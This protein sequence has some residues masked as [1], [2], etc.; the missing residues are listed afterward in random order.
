MPDL[1]ENEWDLIINNI[2]LISVMEGLPLRNKPYMGYSIVTNTKSKEFV[3]PDE[4]YLFTNESGGLV[5]H[6]IT[7]N[8]FKNTDSFGAAY[9]NID[10]DRKNFDV[11]KED[12]TGTE[13]RYYYIHGKFNAAGNMIISDYDSV[14]TSANVIEGTDNNS[15]TQEA[16]NVVTNTARNT[17]YKA[18]Y[19]ER[20]V[21]YKSLNFG[22]L[23]IEQY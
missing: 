2:S 1:D 23:Y 8:G 19:R 6:K 17:Y 7:W 18:L 20:Y 4:I 16:L 12:G 22:N 5:Y 11:V 9:R 15:A 14:V 3:D 10:F 13:K 21:N